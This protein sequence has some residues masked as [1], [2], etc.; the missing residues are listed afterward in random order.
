[1][2]ITVKAVFTETPVLSG[3][4]GQANDGQLVEAPGEWWLV[5]DQTSSGGVWE[6]S[7]GAWTP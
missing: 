1:M 6:T 5:A 3:V 2:A 4:A 7:A